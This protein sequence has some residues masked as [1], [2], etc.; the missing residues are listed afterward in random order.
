MPG[1]RIQMKEGLLYINET[2]VNASA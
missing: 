1:D 2:P